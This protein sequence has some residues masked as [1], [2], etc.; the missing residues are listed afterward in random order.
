MKRQ[1]LHLAVALMTVILYP[2]CGRLG[3]KLGGFLPGGKQDAAVRKAYQQYTTALEAEDINALKEIVS[4]GKQKELDNPQAAVMLKMAKALRP[5]EF[6]IVGVTVSNTTAVIE[7]SGAMDGKTVSG[8]AE[9][10]KEDKGWKLQK[11]GWT[12]TLDIGESPVMNAAAESFM[13]DAA[14]PPQ[15]ETILEGHQDAPSRLLFT[16]DSQYLISASYGDFTIRVWDLATG[17]QISVVKL[18]HRPNDLAL[19]SG[20]MEIVVSDVYKNLTVLPVIGGKIEPPSK[21]VAD[22]GASM[23]MSRDGKR[24]A[25]ATYQK[26]VR[27]WSY[28]D[29]RETETLKGADGHTILAFAGSGQFLVSAS[30]GN[31][32]LVWDMGT[33]KCSKGIVR[34]VSPFAVLSA[35]IGPGDTT[36]VLTYADTS[37]VIL[38]PTTRKE[39][40]NFYVKDSPVS[41]A[42]F[43][44]DGAYMASAND[45][46][47]LLWDMKTGKQAAELKKHEK[48]VTA[49]AFS[50]DGLTLASGGDDRKIILWRSG[51]AAASEGAP[52]PGGGTSPVPA[53]KPKPPEP[54]MEKPK[55]S[56]PAAPVVRK[57]PPASPPPPAA[58]EPAVRPPAPA[59]LPSPAVPEGTYKGRSADD[60]RK[61]LGRPPITA[62]KSGREHYIYP[63]KV[64][65]IVSNGVVIGEMSL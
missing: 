38:D 15:S 45:A 25:S 41:A 32:Y 47:V 5:K 16:P 21:T 63:K 46:R 65:L 17:R 36:L 7:T 12:M 48:N 13:P 52:L 30:E 4:A 53:E 14:K 40:Y 33:G 55:S 27:I 51:R 28:P 31:T 39:I 35:D 43:S 9:F 64:E 29:V 2:G 11:E 24:L 19:V 3:E 59:V 57:E 61:E 22:F 54:A 8:T 62:K 6:K 50:P 10:V 49:L 34:K 44:P 26:P 58:R 23:A 60:V 18:Q 1:V 42:K 56:V 37:I 20:G